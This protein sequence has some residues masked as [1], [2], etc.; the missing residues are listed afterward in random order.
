[1][2]PNRSARAALA[3]VGLYLAATLPLILT[4]FDR[5]RGVHDQINYH[6]PAIL[7]FA[8]QLPLPDLSNYDSATTPGYHLALATIARLITDDVR[9][10]QCVSLLFTLA[11]LT[12]LARETARRSAWLDPLTLTLPAAC[13]LYVFSSGAWLLPDNAGWLGVLAILALALN[14]PASTRALLAAGVL[15]LILVFVRQIHLWAAAVIWAAALLPPSSSA[16][17][18]PA[19]S[20]PRAR[21]P[22]AAT[23]LQ[24]IELARRLAPALLATLPAF[25]LLAALFALWGGL[26]PPMFQ[27]KL[28]GGNPAAPAFILSLAGCYGCFFIP[29]MLDSLR[30]LWRSRR[31]SVLGI[32][33]AALI[34]AALPESTY[35]TAHGRYSG[36]WNIVR[37][38]D[39]A[40]FSISN[41]SPVLLMLSPIGAIVLLTLL[42]AQTLRDR[43]IFAAAI[44]GF[45][46]AQTASRD[47]WQRYS[48][49][50]LLMVIPLMAAS[51]PAPAHEVRRRLA[52]A[53]V[54]ALSA[55]LTAV[56]VVS[57]TM[58]RQAEVIPP[59]QDPARSGASIVR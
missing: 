41:R 28:H 55:A 52:R 53:G 43:L 2:P 31:G 37:M 9:A 48:E 36:L 32:A 35:S 22:S 10:L 58:S 15:L 19:A 6:L 23:R 12:L 39:D 5:G 59:E 45:I 26:T 51:L 47:L 21:P 18:T 44:A 24:L 27:K 20:T 14:R 49:P 34:L 40:G 46:A 16:L 29:L 1:M 50:F 33:L 3:L 30:E 38:L 13:S 54:W 17:D 11:L 4:A 8:E 7:R 56:T 57:L 42:M 25:A